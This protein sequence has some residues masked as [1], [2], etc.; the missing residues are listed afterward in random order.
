VPWL[1]GPLYAPL[2][3]TDSGSET[4]VR[5]PAGSVTGSEEHDDEY[6]NKLCTS[7]C[8]DTSDDAMSL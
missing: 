2:I 4:T 5:A 1:S 3:D 7:V 6:Y 8:E